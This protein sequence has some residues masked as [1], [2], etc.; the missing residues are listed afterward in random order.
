MAWQPPVSAPDF[1]ELLADTRGHAL[2]GGYK[3]PSVGHRNK[4]E[5]GYAD[6]RSNALLGGYEF[7][8][9]DNRHSGIALFTYTRDEMS[10]NSIEQTTF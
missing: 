9:V 5:H 1:R 6:T 7:P 2:L 3:F 4:P 8:S 10:A